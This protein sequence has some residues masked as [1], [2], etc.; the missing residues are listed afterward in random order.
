MAAADERWVLSWATLV[1]AGDYRCI[2]HEGWYCHASDVLKHLAAQHS[3]LQQL[4]PMT[5]M[6]VP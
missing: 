3:L 4:T 6:T 2:N 1:S 5:E